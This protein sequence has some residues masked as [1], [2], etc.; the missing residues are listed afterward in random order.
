MKFGEKSLEAN[1]LHLF[2]Q[3]WTLHSLQLIRFFMSEMCPVT[4]L[5][6]LKGIFTCFRIFLGKILIIF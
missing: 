4:G 5:W 3:K 2:I 1:V 6:I